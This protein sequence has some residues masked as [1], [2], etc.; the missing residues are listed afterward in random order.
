MPKNLSYHFFA[1]AL[2]LMVSSCNYINPDEAIPAYISVD[3]FY[4]KTNIPFQGPAN[5]KV[6]D[7]WVYVDGK[8]VGLYEM[9]FEV[10]VIAIGSS[11]VIIFPGIRNNGIAASRV[12]YPFYKSFQT[13]VEF[14]ELQ[15]ITLSPQTE[16]Y[17]ETQFAWFENFEDPGVSLD[18]TI[19]SDVALKDSIAY[20]SKVGK[21]I[22]TPGLDNFD[23]E[24]IDFY[25]FPTNNPTTYIEMDYIT[26]NLFVV[27]INM[28]LSETVIIQPLIYLN[29]IESWNKIYIDLTYYSQSTPDAKD[30]KVFFRA[31]R[32]DTITKA[33]ILIDNLKLVHF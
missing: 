9:P 28:R 5:H 17:Q 14:E 33:V 10:P 21:I 8:F 23:A 7:A 4:L 15:T 6:T 24:T 31:V 13:Q 29:P 30:F 1:L 27:G 11:N 19:L 25:E 32:N 3:T 16:Y 26:N 2:M 22:L 18:T 12:I 20:G